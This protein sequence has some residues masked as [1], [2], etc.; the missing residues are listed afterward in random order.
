MARRS[1]EWNDGLAEDLKD[2]NFARE[3]LLAAIEEDISIQAALGKVIRAYGVKEFSKRV[4]I[5][6][7]NILRAINPK[8]NPT[9]ETINK[10]LI[11][12]KLRLS[13]RPIKKSA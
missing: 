9:L 4:H 11:P 1:S 3:F 12:F 8:S 7:S 2:F 5:P 13:F 6:S 10:L